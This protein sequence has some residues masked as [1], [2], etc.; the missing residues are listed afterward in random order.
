MAGSLFD[1]L[2]QAGLV[3]EKKAKKAK[4][5][6]YQQSKKKKGKKGQAAG[7]DATAVAAQQAQQA[8]QQKV[9][10]DRQLNLERQQQQAQKAEQAAVR[11]MIDSNRLR[12]VAGDDRFNFVDAN[13]VKTVYINKPV[14]QQLVDGQVRVARLDGGYA[15]LPKAV[16]EKIHQRDATVLIPLAIDETLSKED[17]DHYSQFE[18]P[19][20]LDW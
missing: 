1:Q 7:D 6:K 11:Q 18:V 12:D 3:D 19:D 14:H 17:Q 5:Q 20:D 13:K 2:K 16:A 10:R 4:Q 9:A 8:Q 15:L